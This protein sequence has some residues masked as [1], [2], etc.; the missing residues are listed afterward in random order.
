MGRLIIKERVAMKKRDTSVKIVQK[1]KK[2]DK[3]KVKKYDYSTQE[4]HLEKELSYKENTLDILNT[5]KL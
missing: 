2:I 4:I 5:I 1:G 3:D